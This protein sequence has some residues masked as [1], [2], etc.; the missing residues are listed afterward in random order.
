MSRFGPFER[1]AKTPVAR[2][3][4]AW[5]PSSNLKFA[6]FRVQVREVAKTGVKSVVWTALRSK[7]LSVSSPSG[8]ERPPFRDVCGRRSRRSRWF[9]PQLPCPKSDNDGKI[10]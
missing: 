4:P 2:L 5:R 6:Y 7:V 8:K 3:S 10:P 1:R 9:Q